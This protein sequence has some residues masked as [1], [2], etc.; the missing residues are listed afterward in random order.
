MI[1]RAGASLL[2]PCARGQGRRP[3]KRRAGE[4]DHSRCRPMDD[5][6]RGAAVPECRLAE[7]RAVQS[8]ARRSASRSVNSGRM[9]A[10]AETQTADN[11]EARSLAR[12]L[13]P[14]PT[15]AVPSQFLMRRV[16]PM[17]RHLATATAL[18]SPSPPWPLKIRR[19]GN[20]YRCPFGHRDEA[21]PT[22]RLRVNP[23]TK[24]IHIR[25]P[26]A[27]RDRPTP[28]SRG[29]VQ[30]EG[31]RS[32]LPLLQARCGR[33]SDRLNPVLSCV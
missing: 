5:S 31:N 3:E 1:R 26:A 14:L 10:A 32:G 18:D 13:S 7:R 28:P 22:I 16:R 9:A 4:R 12:P 20:C 6:G 19:F 2:R 25:E 17:P 8:P 21:L 23:T 11:R 15:F 33:N 29:R 30:R 24:S 27:R